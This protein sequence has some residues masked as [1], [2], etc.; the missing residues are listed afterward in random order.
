MNYKKYAK[1]LSIPLGGVAGYLYYF[2][3][4]CQSGSCPIQSNPYYSVLYG[5]LLGAILVMPS[6]NK[7]AAGENKQ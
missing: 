7:K 5:A 3:I 4:G 6:K 1:Y 2:Y